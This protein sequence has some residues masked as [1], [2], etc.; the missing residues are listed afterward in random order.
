MGRQQSL[1]HRIRP[2]PTGQPHI[3]FMGMNYAPE[4]TG[5]APYTTGV[6]E[7]LAA[8]GY[9]VS[10]A[11]T[12]PHYPAWQVDPAYRGK[13]RLICTDTR[14][15]VTVVR[16]R[17]YVPKQ[18]S[19]LRRMLYD[20]TLALNTLAVAPKVGRVRLVVAI[21]PPLQLALTA[22]FIGRMN[23]APVIL[24]LQDVVPDVALTTGTVDEGPFVY[25]ARRVE[26]YVYQKA[27]AI[28]VISA[29]IGRN[30]ENK[31]VPPKKVRVLPN[32]S[33]LD[34]AARTDREALRTALGIS[35]GHTLLLHT[36]N[37][38]AKQGLGS[39]IDAMSFL[40]Q[41]PVV[42]GLVG[43]GQDRLSLE[44]RAA[45]LAL[46]TVK[47]VPLQTDFPSTLAAAD[48][49]VINQ[50]TGVVDTVAPSKLLAY[51]AAGKPVLA[52]VNSLSEAAA[53]IR[54][55]GCGVVVTPGNPRAFAD[56]VLM[57]KD[58]PELR[59]EMGHAGKEYVS[60]RFSKRVT[61]EKWAEFVAHWLDFGK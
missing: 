11:T 21:L 29:G 60:S 22:L 33:S 20:S 10:V 38:G 45:E 26:S 36:G 8:T 17:I 9:R 35:P 54:E 58:R 55:A 14:N 39:A 51:M 2:V 61:L 3:L 4:V 53:I 40:R 23:N 49:L 1:A 57:L 32:W 27:S 46:Q 50:V 43:D 37:M 48:A 52:A 56:A 13:R 25:V 47:F 15:D 44:K 12:F 28:S 42:L 31:G 34:T 16:T 19:F 24:H 30:L 7:Y 41:E 18:R 6:A 59:L 5:I